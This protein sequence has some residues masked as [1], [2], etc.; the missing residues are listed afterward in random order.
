VTYI[1]RPDSLYNR[2]FEQRQRLKE[3]LG[4]RWRPLVEAA[5]RRTKTLFIEGLTRGEAEAIRR[6][7]SVSPDRFWR[8]ATGREFLGLPPRLVQQEFE[9]GEDGPFR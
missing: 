3:L 8:A 2:R 4:R 7:L 1:Y 9:F 6:V 5:K